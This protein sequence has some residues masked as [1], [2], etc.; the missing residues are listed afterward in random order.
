M[1][2]S[3]LPAM[4]IILTTPCEFSLGNSFQRV[5]ESYDADNA[6]EMFENPASPAAGN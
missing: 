5:S 1:V 3:L 6:V 4:V 2:R